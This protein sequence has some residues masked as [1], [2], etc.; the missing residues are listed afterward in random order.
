MEALH[1]GRYKLFEDNDPPQQG[2]VNLFLQPPNVHNPAHPPTSTVD[3]FCAAGYH[4]RKV[5]ST[6]TNLTSL[7]ISA[8]S[9]ISPLRAKL[10]DKSQKTP[11]NALMKYWNRILMGLKHLRRLGI[12]YQTL[13]GD[14]ETLLTCLHF[15]L[16]LFTFSLEGSVLD[17]EDVD[18]AHFFIYTQR[19]T[20]TKLHL[21]VWN[22]KARIPLIIDA[23]SEL[24]KV[25]NFLSEK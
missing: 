12:V 25:R 7:T 4:W 23:L 3:H 20:L 13:N 19:E 11:S 14:L 2:A 16:K 10:I 21:G 9:T 24:N 5:V 18:Y 6:F 17:Q 8:V 1:I 22:I 15:H